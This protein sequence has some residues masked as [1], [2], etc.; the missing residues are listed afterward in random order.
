[1]TRK[2]TG[3]QDTVNWQT[4]KKRKYLY[5]GPLIVDKRKTLDIFRNAR[6][7]IEK[8]GQD[9]YVLEMSQ[10]HAMGGAS[11][12]LTSRDELDKDYIGYKGFMDYEKLCERIKQLYDQVEDYDD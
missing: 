6:D 11:Y 3:N 9:N 4:G 2:T 1:M 7:L 12:V 5:D 10:P 8:L